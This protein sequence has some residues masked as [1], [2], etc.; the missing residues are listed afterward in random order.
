MEK[1]IHVANMASIS[2]FIIFIMLKF[3]LQNEIVDWKNA[4]LGAIA[5]WVFIYFIHNYLNRAD[6]VSR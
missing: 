5:F 1:T 2:Y 4:L 3:L 6:P